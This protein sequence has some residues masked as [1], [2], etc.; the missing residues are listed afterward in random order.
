MSTTTTNQ[1]KN[2]YEEKIAEQLDQWRKELGRLEDKARELKGESKA[3]IDQLRSKGAE[4]EAKLDELKRSGEGAWDEIRHGVDAA[5]YDLKAATERARQS[6][7]K[8]S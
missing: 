2:E 6:L 5:F 1:S 3:T 7:I 8:I 4:F